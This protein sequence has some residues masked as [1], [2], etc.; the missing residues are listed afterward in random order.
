MDRC[1]LHNPRKGGG[2]PPPGRALTGNGTSDLCT[3]GAHPAELPT[4]GPSGECSLR[5]SSVRPLIF[6]LGVSLCRSRK[7]YSA[8]RFF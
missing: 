1:L 8:V 4:Q 2:S 3:D 5:T 6:N 7:K